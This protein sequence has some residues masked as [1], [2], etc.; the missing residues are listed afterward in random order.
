MEPLFKIGDTL[1]IVDHFDESK[2]GR[3]VTVINSFNHVRKTNASIVDVWEYKVKEIT[4]WEGWIS[5][6]HLLPLNKPSNR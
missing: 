3:E 4:G 2:I 6:Y 5:E 1:R